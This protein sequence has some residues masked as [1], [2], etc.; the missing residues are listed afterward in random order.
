MRES[1]LPYRGARLLRLAFEEY[2]LAFEVIRAIL[3]STKS[4]LERVFTKLVNA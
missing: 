1:C 2:C 3:A 4:E